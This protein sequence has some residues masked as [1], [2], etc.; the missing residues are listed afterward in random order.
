MNNEKILEEFDTKFIGNIMLDLI[1]PTTGSAK[2]I[3]AFLSEK[4]DQARAEERERIVEMAE[5]IIEEERY[6]GAPH[7]INKLIE[8]LQDNPTDKE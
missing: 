3:R 1:S 7:A 6:S 5:Q 4:L 2:N 8:S